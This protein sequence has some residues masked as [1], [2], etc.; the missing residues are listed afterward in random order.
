MQDDSARKTILKVFLPSDTCWK[1]PLK[2][3][4]R[5]NINI[6]E[7]FLSIFLAVTLYSVILDLVFLK[8]T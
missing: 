5:T 3:L 4:T 8:A 2:V 6:L 1:I 7:H